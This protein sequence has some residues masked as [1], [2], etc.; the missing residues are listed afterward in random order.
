[1]KRLKKFAG[2]LLAVTMILAYSVTAFAAGNGSITIT[3]AVPGQVYTIYRILDLESYDSTTNAYAYTANSDWLNWLETQTQYVEIT[4]DGQNYVTWKD[5]ADAAEFAKAALAYAEKAGIQPIATA[6]A[7][8]AAEGENRTTVEFT[9]LDLGYYLVD[10][11][12]GTL[13][14]LDTT[15]D[16]AEITEKNDVPSTEKEVQEDSDKSWGLENTAQ[17]GDTVNF[18]TT[19]TAQPGA[20][21]YVLH[22]EMSAG[23]TLDVE[24][25]KVTVDGTELTEE[26]DYTIL[27]TGLTDSCDFE[28]NFDQDYLNSIESETAIVVTYSAVLNDD[29]EIYKNPN[30]NKTYLDYGDDNHTTSTP[31]STTK[32]YSFSFD[33]VKTDN[34]L[35]LLDGAEFELYGAQTG[36]NKIALVDEGNGV[37]R[38]ATNKEI[39]EEGFTSAVIVAKDGQAT[40]KGLDADTTYYLEETKAPDGYNKLAERV[41][42]AIENTNLSTSLE[43]D[44]WTDDD[45]GVQITNISG[46]LLPSTGG[47]G[48]TLFYVGGGIL[49]AGAAVLLVIRKSRSREE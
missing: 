18:K 34:D 33:I 10:T 9:G 3:N 4:D 45:G 41:E 26:D 15:D 35:K 21:N 16:D 42:V 20:E 24:S 6:T 36:G 37:Y 49:M 7:G 29:A 27:T 22:D 14:S 44:V 38:V 8:A 31:P 12:L 17:I 30:E 11:S 25:I 46:A 40:V 23:L 47:M 32:T 39:A 2:L 43:G 19:I 1:M 13:C 48:T 28:I 5:G